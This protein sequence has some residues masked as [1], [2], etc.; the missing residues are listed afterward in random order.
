VDCLRRGTRKGGSPFGLLLRARGHA[1][2]QRKLRAGRE[3]C[4]QAE[5]AA[6]MHGVPVE[7]AADKESFDCSISVCTVPALYRVDAAMLPCVYAVFTGIRQKN[8]LVW[9]QR[10]LP[11]VSSGRALPVLLPV[12]FVLRGCYCCKVQV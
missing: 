8:D 4:V 9:D 7:N 1:A 2:M 5:N 3:C 6:V 10:L 12:P 11:V